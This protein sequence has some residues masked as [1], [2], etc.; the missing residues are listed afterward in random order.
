MATSP[1]RRGGRAAREVG[2][3]A[4]EAG[5][6]ADEAPDPS[7]RRA[8]AR[9]QAR[10]GRAAPGPAATRPP[11]APPTS[12]SRSALVER[13]EPLGGVCLN[14]GCIPSKALLHVAKVIAEAEDAARAGITFG[15]PEIDLDKLRAWKDGVVGKLTGGLD[16]LAKQRK[17]EVVRGDGD[18]HR[19]E[20]A[21]EV[22]GDETVAFEHASSP[23]ARA[24][25]RCP[26]LP[27]D[28]R[29]IDSTGALELADIPER[30]L[31]IGG[32]I[33]GL[34]M[35]TVYDALG[36]K[37][38]VVELLDQLIPGCDQDLVRPLQK[39]IEGRYE[40]IHLN[41]EGRVG[42]S[43]RRR[44]QRHVRRRRRARRAVF[45]RVLVAVG[46]RAQRRGR[47]ASRRRASTVDERGFIAVDE[48]MRT[49]VAAHLR[50]RRRRRR[51]DARPQGD[52]RGQGRRRGDRRATTSPSTPRAIPSVAYTDPEVAWMRADRDRGQGAGHRRTRRPSSRG[53]RPAARSRWAAPRA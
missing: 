13:Y 8:S 53:R 19:A 14:V 31:V 10:R 7:R 24:R 23:P 39:R 20:R 29:I 21:V 42:R 3:D 35:A 18:V 34:E 38:T 40:A 52:A 47:S 43:R 15:E 32:G 51:A 46:R 44:A 17:V 2:S 50:D 37:V 49:N 11:S 9:R 1:R 6:A 48:Q 36:S 22:D 41:D 26:V 33:I 25:R 28:A 5:A 4:A 27:E 12:G 16:G 30:L 45:D